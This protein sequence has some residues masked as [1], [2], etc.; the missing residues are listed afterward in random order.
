MNH[1]DMK[2]QAADQQISPDLSLEIFIGKTCS[3]FISS[4]TFN[5]LFQ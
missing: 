4:G 2:A 1:S 3:V 5:S